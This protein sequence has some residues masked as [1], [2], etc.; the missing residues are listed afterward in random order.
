MLPGLAPFRQAQPRPAASAFCP[1]RGF[2]QCRADDGTELETLQSSGGDGPRMSA[3][4]T[5]EIQRFCN[6]P[7]DAI[8]LIARLANYE[9]LEWTIR[10]QSAFVRE[11]RLSN[12][13][14]TSR[15]AISL[16]CERLLLAE[17]TRW[18]GVP[19]CRLKTDLRTKTMPAVAYCEGLLWPKSRRSR[20]SAPGSALAA[21]THSTN[22]VPRLRPAALRPMRP[23]MNR[24][25]FSRSPSGIATGR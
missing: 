3:R 20:K 14:R 25:I 17:S 15:T 19:Q 7:F 22:H 16:P 23:Y 18:T 24:A 5:G 12:V 13:D 4:S 2:M 10:S 9:P 6:R 11:R 8:R 21:S 1:V